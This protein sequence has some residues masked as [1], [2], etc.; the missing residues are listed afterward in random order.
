VTVL[1]PPAGNTVVEYA[2]ETYEV[3]WTASDAGSD[4]TWVSVYLNTSPVLDGNEFILPQSLNTD[5]TVGLHVINSAG[6]DPGTYWVYCSV[7]DGGTTT[8]DWSEGT[9]TFAVQTPCPGD[10]NGDR[11]VASDDLQALLDAWGASQLDAHY[12]PAADFDLNGEIESADL[13][14]LLDFWSHT[15]E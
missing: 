7:T 12:N 9:I 10:T 1:D 2:A 3:H 5:G 14:V 8:G 11:M 15:C 6:F 13:Q 4:P